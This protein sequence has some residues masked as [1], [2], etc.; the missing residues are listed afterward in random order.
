MLAVQ[1]V[2][3]CLSRRRLGVSRIRF[4]F[5]PSCEIAQLLSREVLGSADALIH[6][7]SRKAGEQEV[8]KRLICV[9]F[10]PKVHCRLARGKRALRVPPRDCEPKSIGPL[11][12]GGSG[13]SLANS[14]N[15]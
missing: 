4:E 5:R 3:S 2:D 9:A 8:L 12:G 7:E 11:K 14:V 15:G 1:R 10:A 6:K 13:A